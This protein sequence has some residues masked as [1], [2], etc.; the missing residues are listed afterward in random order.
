MWQIE[1]DANQLES[2]LVNLAINARDAMPYGGKLTIE[3]ANVFADEEYSLAN[4]EIASGQYVVICV[5]D[6]GMSAGTLSHVFEP[7]FTTKELGQGTG[8][9]LSQVYG[10]V[11]QSGGHVKIYSE[12]GQGTTI[13][14]YM[15]RYT[16]KESDEENLEEE[17][18]EEGM[19]DETILVVEDDVDVRTYLAE[20]LRNLNYRVITAHNAQSA[21]TTLLQPE[22][23][24]DLSLTDIVMPGLGG[25]DLGKRAQEIRPSLPIL[26][27]TGYS[28]NAIVH[29]GRLDEGVEMLQKPVS[30]ASLALR[31]KGWHTSPL[32]YPLEIE[33]T[34]DKAASNRRSNAGGLNGTSDI[35]SFHLDQTSAACF[36][37][38][39]T[40]ARFVTKDASFEVAA[41]AVWLT[42]ARAMEFGSRRPRAMPRG[43][44]TGISAQG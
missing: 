9:G 27:M 4:P 1:V 20:V 24:V 19:L 40:K 21:L 7:F 16:G 28:R 8:L 33:Q 37:T 22:R 14:V 3:A 41:I 17:S 25:R 31:V 35:P 15:P 39:T 5:T 44:T 42:C 34:L 11:K 12:L 43:T 32:L 36:T 2:G 29:Q 6:T 23:R 10:F 30:Q 18:L 26:Y 38:A 13:K